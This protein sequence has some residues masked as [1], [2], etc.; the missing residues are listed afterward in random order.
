MSYARTR[1]W[2]DNDRHFGPLTFAYTK[3]YRPFCVVLDSGKTSGCHIR[4]SAFG[5]GNVVYLPQVKVEHGDGTRSDW[6]G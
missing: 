1:R 2:S 5:G 3:A 6:G 4:F